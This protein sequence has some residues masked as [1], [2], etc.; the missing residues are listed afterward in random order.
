MEWSTLTENR[1]LEEEVI[2]N[3]QWSGLVCCVL[4]SAVGGKL[5]LAFGL[6]VVSSERISVQPSF[7]G[8]KPSSLTDV[9]GMIGTIKVQ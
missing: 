9:S 7:W 5:Y 4:N 1:F 3:I 8:G 2:N 6:P